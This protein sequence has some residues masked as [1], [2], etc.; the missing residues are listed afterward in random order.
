MYLIFFEM[1]GP[2]YWRNEFEYVKNSI[3]LTEQRFTGLNNVPAFL[4]KDEKFLHT[5]E[6]SFLFVLLST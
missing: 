6:S 5:L 4:L 2:D 1:I 3:E